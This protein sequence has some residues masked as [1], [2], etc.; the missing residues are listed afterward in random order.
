MV[1][2]AVA[3]ARTPSPASAPQLRD[4]SPRLPVSSILL[5]VPMARWPGYWLGLR[6][7]TITSWVSAPLLWTRSD[8]D[9]AGTVEGTT[10]IRCIIIPMPGQG[11][12]FCH[13][14]T[15]LL[16]ALRP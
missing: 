2:Q 8:T 10:K 3:P 13:G 6:G 5:S 7:S 14:D 11:S 4:A 16:G 9:P 1:V 12:P 15:P